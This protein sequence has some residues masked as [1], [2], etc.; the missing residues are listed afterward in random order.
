MYS[1]IRVS[2]YNSAIDPRMCQETCVERRKHKDNILED[3]YDTL[4]ATGW[5]MFAM[6]E[7]AN[8]HS[9]QEYC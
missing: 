9:G 2:G 1:A 6:R 8:Q 5:R 7:T 4:E 3:I